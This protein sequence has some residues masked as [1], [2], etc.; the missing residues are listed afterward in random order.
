MIP[1]YVEPT[2]S[3]FIPNVQKHIVQSEIEKKPYQ[4]QSQQPFTRQSQSGQKPLV[5]LQ[6][7]APPS[8]PAPK[9]ETINPA[10]YLP[11]P[12]QTPFGVPPQYNPMWPNFYSPQLVSPIVKQ[13]SINQGPFVNYSTLSVVKEDS[14]P[15]YFTNTFNT[16]G[17]RIH[18]YNFIR[19][20]F[21]K[22]HDGEDIDLDG[23]G[24]N[25]LLSYLKFLQ[26]NPYNSQEY[27]DNPYRGLPDDML[28]Y[29]SCYPI[30]YDGQSNSVQCAPN[31]IGMNIRI[32]KLSIGE[33]NI[34]KLQQNNFYD[35]DNWREI[36]YYEYIR[37]HIIKRKISPNFV[38][39][40]GYYIAEKVN[41]DF[42]KLQK[43]KSISSNTQFNVS[44]CSKPI[45]FNM[46][47]NKS[48]LDAYS[49]KALVA[50]T[51]APTYNIYGWSSRTY[52]RNGNIQKM[53][54]PG[55]HT[56]EV[57]ISVLFQLMVSMY[58]LQLHKIAFNNFTVE[59]NVYI[60]DLTQHENVVM[61]WKYRINGF[62]YY[63]PNYGYLV[64][65]DTNFK[66][67]EP[68]HSTLIK[69]TGN[70]SYKIYSNIFKDD[71]YDDSSINRL[72]FESFKTAFNPNS[73]S[74][75]FTNY[76]GTPPPEDIK[77]LL[78]KIYADATSPHA[79][80]DIGYYLY[81]YMASLLNNRIGTYLTE[82]EVKNV[83]KDDAKPFEKGQIVVHEKPSETYKFVVFVEQTGSSVT[84]LT[85]EDPRKPDIIQTTVERSELFNYS[86][87]DTILQNYKPAEANL[88]EEEL[89][90][91]YV[92]GI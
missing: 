56:S 17:E 67:I 86:R 39:L 3:P 9:K 49:G 68:D 14:L 75:V 28:I 25:S 11:I 83:R 54:N 12:T 60:K 51:E 4:Q 2:N 1:L 35:Y 15:A 65:I 73:F 80:T 33:Y 38:T 36:A 19:S 37:E 85:K 40:Y 6:V 82:L 23:K 26:L 59:D 16:L 92:V 53:I 30:R 43:V 62:E 79:N 45:P 32:Y 29:R 77:A 48:E 61:Y 90:E 84:I 42:T 88:N 57:W 34:K 76:G 72:A 7:Y 18:L 13:Y 41:I 64:L 71:V 78:E 44:P 5:D 70:K 58:I 21:I 22:Y 27:P 81:T 55:Y 52:S 8:R 74:K 46:N 31:S 69:H 89:L 10:M 91:T 47:I 24:K 87:Y 20:V 66:N 50:L 63:V